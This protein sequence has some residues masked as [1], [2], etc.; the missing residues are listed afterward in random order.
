MS[1]K[2]IIDKILEAIDK[3]VTTKEIR[4]NYNKYL[5]SGE[6]KKIVINTGGEGLIVS[7]EI[8]DEMKKRGDKLATRLIEKDDFY[9][10][11]EYYGSNKVKKGDK[12]Y[13]DRKKQWTYLE[14]NHKNYD[15]ENK[16][17][18]EILEENKLR[19]IGGWSLEVEKVPAEEWAYEIRK[20]DDHWG[21]EYVDMF[22]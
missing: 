5:I 8:I 2:I 11:N 4:E 7:Y 13:T 18:I 22:I 20:G 9:I 12:E 16:I 10:I 1:S 15:R 17:L 21:S 6:E 3:G 19:N 14:F